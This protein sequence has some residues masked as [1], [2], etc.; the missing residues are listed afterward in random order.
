MSPVVPCSRAMSS[1]DRVVG[2]EEGLTSSEAPADIAAAYQQAMSSLSVLAERCRAHGIDPMAMLAATMGGVRPD[3]SVAA[4]TQPTQMPLGDF[5]AITYSHDLIDDLDRAEVNAVD[6]ALAESFVGF[7]GVRTKDRVTILATI[8]QRRSQV[9]SIAG[10]TWTEDQVID[11][12]NTVVFIGKAHEVLGGNETKG[13]YVS[14][15]WYLLQ[16]IRTDDRWQVHLLTWQAES[17]DHAWWDDTFHKGRGFSREPNRLLVAAVEDVQPGAA[18][19]LAMG[20]GRNALYLASHGWNVTGVD[21]SHEG[22]RIAREQATKRKLALE[23]VTADIDEWDFGENRYDLVTLIYAGDDAR[24]IDR[25]KTALRPGG[26]FVVEGW[27]KLATSSP[28]GFSDGQLRSL[29]D[30]YQIIHDAVV[31]DV[32]DWA[33]DTGK[34]ARFVARKA[35]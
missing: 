16:W 25:I 33:H 9:P 4:A 6:A 19:D 26:L 29:F 14:D 5:D 30:G 18:L 28:V 15:G 8:R 34:L 12:G 20:Q 27:A 21:S 10:R 24:W 35:G 17:T 2:G 3:H 22:V 11:K 31:D 23:C 7:D 13:G 32:P 1:L